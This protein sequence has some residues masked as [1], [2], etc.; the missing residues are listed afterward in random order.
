M[1]EM[2]DF[3]LLSHY[4]IDNFD[5]DALSGYYRHSYPSY[6]RLGDPMHYSRSAAV[7]ERCGERYKNLSRSLACTAKNARGDGWMIERNENGYEWY[8]P[9]C[10]VLHDFGNIKFTK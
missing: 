5:E 8:C 6:S 7:C 2:A 1:S 4:D 3:V 10:K 9:K